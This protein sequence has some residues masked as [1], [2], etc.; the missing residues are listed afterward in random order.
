MAIYVLKEYQKRSIGS[1]LVS[2]A[3]NFLL[4]K[5][6]QSMLVWVL[7]E[8]PSREFYEKLGAK[9]IGDHVLILDGEHYIESAYGWTD[10]K[11]ILSKYNTMKE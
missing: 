4:N 11:I 3:V 9:Y 10:I 8:N 2:L 1:N 6:V 5:N 7:K